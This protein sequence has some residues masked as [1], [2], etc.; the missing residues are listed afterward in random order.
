MRSLP[1]TARLVIVREGVRCGEPD[2]GLVRLRAAREQTKSRIAGVVVASGERLQRWLDPLDYR[3]DV[4]PKDAEFH[5]YR[6]T[7]EIKKRGPAVAFVLDGFCPPGYLRT[8]EPYPSVWLATKSLE[9]YK[10]KDAE[11]R[12]FAGELRRELGA[13]AADWDDDACDD[14]S[15]PLVQYLTD[16]DGRPRCELIFN[17][18]NLYTFAVEALSRAL[19]ISEAVDHCVG[20]VLSR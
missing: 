16:Y 19:G 15:A 20:R 4:Y 2:R 1:D 6:K 14:E 5:V 12:A 11:R 9:N 3:I 7:W 17:S 10:M 13:V 8:E 18:D